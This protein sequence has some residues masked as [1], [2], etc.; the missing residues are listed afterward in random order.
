MSVMYDT[1]TAGSGLGP[2]GD[3]RLIPDW[4]TLRILPYS[5][6]HTSVMSNMHTNEGL[7][8]PLCPRNFL[9]RM[10]TEASKSGLYL[11]AA[12]ENEFVLLMQPTNGSGVVPVD[13]TTYCMTYS[14][15]LNH[16][17][18]ADICHNLAE[19]GVEV[20]QYYPESASGQHEISI[21][22]SDAM[23]AADQQIVFR[24]TVKAVA[25]K[26]KMVASFLPKIFPNQAGGHF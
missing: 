16:A 24:E 1:I 5:K 19:Q 14:M 3:L 23:K 13:D 10:T 4:D 7:P 18:I 11:K 20:E 26:H 21:L 25:L 8:S 6:G 12:F 9:K 22:Y 15:D 2:I 17:V